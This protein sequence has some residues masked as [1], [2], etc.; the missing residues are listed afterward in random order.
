MSKG[1][2]KGCL[3]E[4][5]AKS[6][7]RAGSL[8]PQGLALSCVNPPTDTI[9]SLTQHHCVEV[10]GQGRRLIE[11]ESRHGQWVSALKGKGFVDN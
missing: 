9:V 2:I 11:M 4:S 3:G 6:T 7:G 1:E 10:L 8:R 5:T